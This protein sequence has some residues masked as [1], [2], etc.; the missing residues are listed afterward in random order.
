MHRYSSVS[1][2]VPFSAILVWMVMIPISL[3]LASEATPGGASDER[4]PMVVETRHT[5][6]EPFAIDGPLRTFVGRAARLRIPL[7][8]A[9]NGSPLPDATLFLELDDGLIPEPATPASETDNGEPTRFRI[10]ELTAAELASGEPVELTLRIGRAGPLTLRIGLESETMPIAQGIRTLIG[11]EPLN[12]LPPEPLPKSLTPA[13]P[14][15]CSEWKP[16]HFAQRLRKP[17]PPPPFLPETAT[18]ATPTDTAHCEN[19]DGSGGD[20][21]IPLIDPATVAETLRTRGT[22]TDPPTNDTG[23]PWLNP[24]NHPATRDLGE[25]IPDASMENASHLV[26]LK[27]DEPVWIERRDDQPVGVLVQGEICNRDCPLELFA[28]LG[29]G[30]RNHESIVSC[31]VLASTVHAALLVCGAE[32]GS[33]ARWEWPTAT[34]ENPG[35]E[36]KNIDTPTSETA[37]TPPKPTFTPPSGTEIDVFVRWRDEEGM[38]HEVRAQEWMRATRSDR[39]IA[40]PFVFAGSRFVTNPNTGRI[41]YGADRD[42]E[43]ICVSNFA[44]AT[45]DVPFESTDT[46]ANLEFEA[47]TDRI[48]PVGTPVTLHLKSRHPTDEHEPEKKQSEKAENGKADID[49]HKALAMDANDV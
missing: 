38:V 26:R 37:A 24:A 28:T 46:N 40:W 15:K 31:P 27:P 32:P 9:P 43:F 30:G 35:T 13:D 2:T 6:P 25:P 23:N 49:E 8:T 47:W 11:V 17:F 5:T 22:D 34:D 29:R 10:R 12:P 7:P 18:A 4:L 14:E 41:F 1:A 36:K 39:P 33:P 42:E 45:L 21:T 19:G 16:D 44:S 3:S 48:P 20:T